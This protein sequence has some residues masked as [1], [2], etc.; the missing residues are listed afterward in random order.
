MVEWGPN[1]VNLKYDSE[2]HDTFYRIFRIY[3][4]NT[5][6][7]A[8]FVGIIQH[9][10][11]IFKTRITYILKTYLAWAS[12]LFWSFPKSSFSSMHLVHLLVMVSSVDAY[13]SWMVLSVCNLL[14]ATH[15]LCIH[16]EKCTLQILLLL[17]YTLVEYFKQISQIWLSWS[18]PHYI[19]SIA[20]NSNTEG[21]F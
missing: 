20:W 15:W 8:Y 2:T 7:K 10:L 11:S 3:S 17:I 4:K 9:F 13:V 14:C 1:K 6:I 18:Y 5:E 16:M 19:I 21:W 12:L